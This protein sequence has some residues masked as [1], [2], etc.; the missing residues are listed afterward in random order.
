M[1]FLFSNQSS[2]G[3][4]QIW[5]NEGETKIKV[6]INQQI[7]LEN[8]NLADVIFSK[9]KLIDVPCCFFLLF[10]FPMVYRFGINI[11]AINNQYLHFNP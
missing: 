8:E 6:A 10:S 1:I 2:F 4:Y 7:T 5:F 3:K 9:R 11:K